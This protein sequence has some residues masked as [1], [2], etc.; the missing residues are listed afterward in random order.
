MYVILLALHFLKNKIPSHFQ[1]FSM[2]GYY[3]P[4]LFYIQN[5][6][7]LTHSGEKLKAI[8]FLKEGVSEKGNFYNI[9]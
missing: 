1:A 7:C 9:A 2:S 4:G 5:T 3:F 8:F 6:F